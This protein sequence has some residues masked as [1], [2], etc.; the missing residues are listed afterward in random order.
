MTSELGLRRT[1]HA[2]L[3]RS[4]GHGEHV[5]LWRE[6]FD[7]GDERECAAAI[8]GT[9]MP[10]RLSGER[11]S[12]FVLGARLFELFDL[13]ALKASTASDRP[14]PVYRRRRVDEPNRG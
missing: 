5:G 12:G 1:R 4:V 7:L 13:F 11:P 10:G 6:R 14:L 8:S 9:C 3:D 2:L